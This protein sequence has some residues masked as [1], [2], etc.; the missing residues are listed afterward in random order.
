M[1]FNIINSNSAIRGAKFLTSN[2]IGEKLYSVERFTIL[3]FS[4]FDKITKLVRN[5]SWWPNSVNCV[6]ILEVIFTIILKYI[7]FNVFE[8]SGF[9]IIE[10]LSLSIYSLK[11]YSLMIILIVMN[12][13]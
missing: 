5:N 2:V 11:L 12:V 7:F 9:N 3:S 6:S 8:N 4:N 13:Y 1:Y 10:Y